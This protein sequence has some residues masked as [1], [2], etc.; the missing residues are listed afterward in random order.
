M[1]KT[2]RFIRLV[3]QTE[4]LLGSFIVPLW[5]HFDFCMIV[6]TFDIFVVCRP[7]TC[8]S[9]AIREQNEQQKSRLKGNLKALNA[10]DS[11][12]SRTQFSISKELVYTHIIVVRC[13]TRVARLNTCWTCDYYHLPPTG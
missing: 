11:A 1:T 8:M 6:F 2:E 9:T 5:Q 7:S 4:V 12:V 10:E 3:C 13:M